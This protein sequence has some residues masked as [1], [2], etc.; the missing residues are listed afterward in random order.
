[1]V[2]CTLAHTLIIGGKRCL[3]DE[4]R[5][6]DQDSARD[7]TS[8]TLDFRAQKIQ[9]VTGP[10]SPQIQEAPRPCHSGLSACPGLAVSKP[11]RPFSLSAYCCRRCRRSQPAGRERIPGQTDRAKP[12]LANPPLPAPIDNP[13]PLPYIPPIHPGERVGRTRSVAAEGVA[14]E[15][16]QASR[17][18]WIGWACARLHSGERRRAIIA[19]AH[20]RGSRN[21]RHVAPLPNLS[22]TKD[23]GATRA[24]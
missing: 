17:T 24:A 4:I 16:S 15:N 19:G 20:R 9:T 2:E 21:R 8:P 5:R 22:G 6:N 10:R 14:P 11:S 7:S 13:A 1:M 23:R 12:A 3:K 18:G